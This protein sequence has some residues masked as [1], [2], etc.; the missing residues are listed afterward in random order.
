MT[1]V[2]ALTVAIYCRVSSAEQERRGTID[3]Q[4]VTLTAYAA[5]AGYVVQGIYCDDGKSAAT[6]KLDARDAFARLLV[7]AE[8]RLFT[9]VLVVA[10]DRLTRTDDLIERAAI[11]GPLQ[12][13]GV[14]VVTPS[15]TIDLRTFTGDL[16]AGLESAMAALE[17]RKIYERTQAGKERAIA[18]G[19]KPHGRTPYGLRYRRGEGWSA[20]PHEADVIREICRRV[21][22]TESCVRIAL[23]L[24]ARGVPRPGKPWGQALVRSI[25]R[26]A[27][28]RYAGRWVANRNRGVVL[29]V[30]RLLTDEEIERAELAL[31]DHQR[32]GL[33]HR[34]RGIYLLDRRAATCGRCGGWVGVRGH[35][36]GDEAYTCRSRGELPAGAPGRCDAP[37]IPVGHVDGPLWAE[38]VD[39]IA[40]PSLVERAL[41]LSRDRGT[42]RDPAEARRLVED[43]RRRVAD[44]DRRAAALA[45]RV[46]ALPAE[47]LTSALDRLAKERQDAAQALRDA[48]A[49]ARGAHLSEAATDDLEAEIEALRL[50]MASALPDERR[51]LTRALVPRAVLSDHVLAAAVALPGLVEGSSGTREDR[52]RAGTLRIWLAA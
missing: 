34:T 2:Q 21:A 51:A 17:R 33:E 39:L 38:L 10:I 27:R 15:G 23:D 35:G 3:A 5:R 50:R 4:R 29:E 47:L 30:P 7:A 46:D 25:V 49:A 18:A 9:A 48:E 22:G 16:M 36:R 41:R 31:H 32:R 45:G 37:I 26:E 28:D 44:A 20:V 19:G 11:L 14:S 52:A 1:A 43:A 8:R 40:S 42:D 13:A 12:R 6:G 24:E